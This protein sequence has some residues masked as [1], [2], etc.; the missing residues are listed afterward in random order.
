[1]QEEAGVGRNSEVTVGSGIGCGTEEEAVAGPSTAEDSPAKT[2]GCVG[3]A[4]VTRAAQP[5]TRTVRIAPIGDNL[6]LTTG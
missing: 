1:M 6:R 4:G 2:G 3:V 5:A